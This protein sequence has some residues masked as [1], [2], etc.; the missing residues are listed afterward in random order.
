MKV[1]IIRF[2]SIGDIVLTTPIVR[3]LKKQIT[4]CEIH[5][6]TKCNFISLVENN[7]YVSKIYSIKDKVSEVSEELKQENYDVAI[8]L[9]HNLRS[10]QVKRA[11]GCSAHSFNKLNVEK[12]LLVNL[13]INR[14][15]YIHIVDRYFETV[16][17][18]GVTNDNQG[19]DYFIPAKDEV[20]IVSAFQLISKGYHVLVVGGSYYTKK[21][22]LTKLQEICRISDK[23]IILLGGK[24]DKTVG[25]L[26][27]KEFSGKVFSACGKFTIN[28]SAS[29]I[30]QADKVITSDTGL[31]HIAAA[32]KKDI[33]SLWGNTVPE[34]GMYPY[35]A[36]N[37]SKILEVTNLRCRPCSKLGFNKCPK[38]HFKCMNE[39]NVQEI[40]L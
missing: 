33:F 8:D 2:S 34:F 5:F 36:G 20:D 27:E 29:I 16:K 32:F 38:G 39:I 24:E 19:L 17:S 11:V 26:I 40:F 22:P 4:D 12:W 21:I 23:P 6:L 37:H 1:L 31:M 25:E 18:L 10:A 14:L 30:Q 15:P 9:H 3:C 7:P 35:L 28:Q 13:K